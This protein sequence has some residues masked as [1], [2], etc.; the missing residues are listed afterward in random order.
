MLLKE[1]LQPCQR[2]AK[3][4]LLAWLVAGMIFTFTAVR[5]CRESIAHFFGG[6]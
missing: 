2:A 5:A 3:I 4:D 6:V 1:E